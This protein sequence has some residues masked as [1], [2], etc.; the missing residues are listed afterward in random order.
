VTSAEPLVAKLL[1]DPAP[2]LEPTWQRAGFDAM[3]LS[4]MLRPAARAAGSGAPS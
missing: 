2:G 3:R 4:E 1:L